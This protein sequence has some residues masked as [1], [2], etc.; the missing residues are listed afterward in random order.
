MN[1]LI[2]TARPKQWMKNVLVFAAP[3]AAGVLN[4]PRQLGLTCLAFVAMC[5]ASSGTY[6]WNDALDIESENVLDRSVSVSALDEEDVADV[7]VPDRPLAD[8]TIEQLDAR[9]DPRILADD[10]KSEEL[11]ALDNGA[12]V[13]DRGLGLA[14]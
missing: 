13:N 6:Y 8:H 12:F 10:I 5:L 4:E 2:R 7:T 14:A 1:A 3:G 9:S 11:Y